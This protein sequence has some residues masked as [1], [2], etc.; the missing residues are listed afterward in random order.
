MNEA[1]APNTTSRAAVVVWV[2]PEENDEPLPVADATRS[3][4]V[5]PCRSSATILYLDA[6]G[7]LAV[8]FAPAAS[9][10]ARAR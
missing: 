3:T 9:A 8:I 10:L 4:C 6:F 7:K 5:T 1:T 2:S